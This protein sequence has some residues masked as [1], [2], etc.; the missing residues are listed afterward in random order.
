MRGI[1]LDSST[2]SKLKVIEADTS[3]DKLGLSTESYQ[4]L[5]HNVT[6]IVHSA[7][8]MSLNRPIRMY[9]AQFKVM[10]NLI[11]L[12]SEIVAKQPEAFQLGFQFISSLAVVGNYPRLTGEALVPEQL[13]TV[14]SVP[15][16]GYADAKLACEQMLNETLHR[17]S[18]RFRPMAVRIAQI[19]GSTTNG[20]WNPTEYVPFL[21]RSSQTLK[22]LPAL[23]GTLSWYPVN[24]V[25]ATLG[26]LLISDTASDLIYHIENPSRQSWKDMI[27]TLARALDIS[28]DGIIPF[29]SW[30]AKVREFG[31]STQENPALQLIDFFE[32]YFVSM[33]CGGLMLET[34]K[35]MRHSKT[36]ET[37]G[38]VGSELV[39]RYI[40]AWKQS[41]F[42]D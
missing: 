32:H 5:V 30:T 1:A 23:D 33:S 9:H 22:A 26:E 31:G 29:D 4:Y 37:S 25:A 17:H 2:M 3:K 6:H 10:R 15:D 16:A 39:L 19:S 11:D 41:G 13:M 36:L 34:S 20:Y 28:P 35:T 8:P 7:W 18:K 21:V 27:A 14:E 24:E 38:P 12:A 42:L 40:N